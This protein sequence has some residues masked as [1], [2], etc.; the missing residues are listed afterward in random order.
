MLIFKKARDFALNV[1]GTQKY[2]D[3]P[4]IVHLDEVAKVAKEFGCDYEIIVAAYLHDIIED[5][6][7]P[8]KV[9][10]DLFGLR[11]A[12]MVYCVTDEL[13]RNRKERKEKT[14]PKIK[15]NKDAIK[16]KLCD[17]IANIRNAIKN[18][19]KEKINMY[20]KEHYG[21]SKI[22][23]NDIH[24]IELELWKEL[25]EIN[26]QLLTNYYKNK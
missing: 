14:Y 3:K 25:E 16:L 8:Y 5:T 9:I 18:N 19:R 4:Y 6:K 26:K 12:E 17:R 23:S 20:F 15:S 1:H 24:G 2:G 10:K 11:V 21:F 22:L 7:I 13:G